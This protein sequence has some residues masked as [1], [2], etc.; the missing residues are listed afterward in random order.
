MGKRDFEKADALVRRALEIIAYHAEGPWFMENPFT[1][2]LRKRDVVAGIHYARV[3]YCRFG[4]PYRKSTAIW[5]NTALPDLR[6]EGPGWCPAMIGKRHRTTAQDHKCRGHD[7]DVWYST[8]DLYVMPA[9]LC[10]LMAQHAEHMIVN[11]RYSRG[12]GEVGVDSTP[13]GAERDDEG[14]E[15]RAAAGE[16]E[17]AQDE[18]K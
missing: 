11:G 18:A 12:R 6:C 5:T 15:G 8:K 13:Q 10:D 9:K 14:R 2:Y 4:M 7:D 3:D 1:G 17:E 16:A